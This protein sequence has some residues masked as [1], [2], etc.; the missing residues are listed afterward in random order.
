MYTLLMHFENKIFKGK[1][2]KQSDED[3]TTVISYLIMP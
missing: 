3:I 2:P 1:I